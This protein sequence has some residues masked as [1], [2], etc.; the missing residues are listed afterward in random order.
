MPAGT[1]VVTGVP[2]NNPGVHVAAAVV[3]TA[4]PSQQRDTARTVFRE[5]PVGIAPRERDSTR[6]VVRDTE[7]L[8]VIDGVVQDRAGRVRAVRPWGGSMPDTVGTV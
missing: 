5:I 4:L 8:I 6:A 7:P 1:V 3:S 2:L